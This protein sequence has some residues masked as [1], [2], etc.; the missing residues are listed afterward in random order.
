M[1]AAK[2]RT[3]YGPTQYLLLLPIIV[4]S[5]FF[6][7]I[8]LGFSL[9]VSFMSYNPAG[10][11]ETRFVGLLNFRNIFFEKHSFFWKSLLLTGLYTVLAVSLEFVIGLALALLM[12]RDLKGRRLFRI[13]FILPLTIAPS[14]V[15]LIFRYMFN[16]DYGVIN[17]FGKLLGLKQNIPW[18]LSRQTAL[19]AVAIADIWHY[20]PFCFLILLAGLLALPK[21]PYEGSLL[22]G[23][24]ARLVFRKITLPLLK[25]VI[26]VVLLFRIIDSFN[27][28]DKVFVLTRG[29][30]AQATEVLGM[31]VYKTGLQVLR[32]GEGAAISW[33][34]LI[35]LSIGCSYLIRFFS[36]KES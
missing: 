22:E 13:I 33:I 4:Y 16:E 10:S 29:G 5:L 27:I 18:L 12:A 19:L 32:V 35:I 36:R 6:V 25:P 8:P 28:F 11:G 2:R 3:W 34:M 24:S 30:P 15:A 9:G 21:E 1:S 14:I 23:A 26:A 7:L 20:T 31:F 17:F